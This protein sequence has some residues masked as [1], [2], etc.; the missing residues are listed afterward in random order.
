MDIEHEIR[1]L[2]RRVGELEGAVNVVA[3]QVG[4][5]ADRLDTLNTQLWS[6][7]DDM[8]DLVTPAIRA[9]QP[10]QS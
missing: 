3:G 7:R 2:K 9:T 5:V 10:D 8:P 1:E 4:K 6:L